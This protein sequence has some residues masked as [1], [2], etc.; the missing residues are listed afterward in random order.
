[1]TTVFDTLSERFYAAYFESDVRKRRK[2]IERWID[3][4]VPVIQKAIKTDLRSH[5]EQILETRWTTEGW[6]SGVKKFM[7]IMES[8]RL[9]MD[10]QIT[11]ATHRKRVRT[12]D[13]ASLKDRAKT[14]R[15]A[16]VALSGFDELEAAKVSAK[17]KKA[18]A[19]ES[20]GSSGSDDEGWDDSK[21]GRSPN[22]DRSDSMNPNND[23]YQASMDNRSDQMNPNNPAYGSS[24]GR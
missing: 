16:E 15:L 1:M 11:D 14:L 19:S 12:V 9:V 6:Q 21:S 22:D 5:L 8:Y 18:V 13:P 3:S 7:R 4:S 2:A 24:R 10:I 17:G 23:A 20:L